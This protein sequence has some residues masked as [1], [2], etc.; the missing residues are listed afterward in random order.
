MIHALL[1]VGGN[2]KE[3]LTKAQTIIEKSLEQKLNLGQGHPDL[4]LIEP[5]ISIGIEE[6]RQLQKRLSLKPYSSIMKVALITEAEKLTLPAQNAFLKTLEE[7]PARSLIILTAP[8]AELLL[9]TIVSRCQLLK[10]PLKTEIEINQKVIDQELHFTQSILRDSIGE[11][12]KLAEGLAQNRDQAT[13]FCQNQLWLWRKMLLNQANSAKKQKNLP[14]P[15]KVLQVLKAIQST[16]VLLEANV[17]PR[18]AIEA[19]LV[20]FPRLN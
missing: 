5:A 6:I 15:H 13:K 18:L 1:I 3:R 11:R 12:V 2:Q 14:S 19:L 7:P 20:S 4:C 10:L 9:P 8:K 17:N 16:V